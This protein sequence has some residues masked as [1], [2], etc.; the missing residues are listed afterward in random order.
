MS[1]FLEFLALDVELVDGPVEGVFSGLGDAD[2]FG[3]GGGEGD[4]GDRRVAFTFG[5][6]LAPFF[7]V[8]RGLDFVFPRVVAV[9]TAG[10]EGD[11]ADLGAFG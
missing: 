8:A 4:F 2:V 6:G 5:K 7:A 1:G 11:G 3:F 10:V 9:G